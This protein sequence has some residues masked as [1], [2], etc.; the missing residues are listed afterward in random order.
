[1]RL[2]ACLLRWLHRR[3]GALMLS[4]PADLVIGGR[5]S[6]YLERWFVIP[7]NPVLNVYLH[8]FHRSD[9]DRALHDH[10][11]L[12]C[13]VLL[14]GAYREHTI[15]AGGVHHRRDWT[16]GS[17]RVGAPW[18]AHRLELLPEG[19]DR[20]APVTTLFITG[21]RIRSWGFHCPGG[22]RHWRDFTAPED[23]GAIGKGCD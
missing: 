13:S 21:P 23:S 3:A 1:M 14:H 5:E 22:W 18:R 6:P 19:A 16:A 9:D 12:W 7:R 4:R 11:W 2:P 10:P 15:A 20:F 8:L 17:L